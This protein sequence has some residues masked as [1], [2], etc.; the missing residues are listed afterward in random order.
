MS[1]R[2]RIVAGRVLGVAFVVGITASAALA[3]PAPDAELQKVADAFMA[4]WATGDAKAL[5]ALHT[6]EAVRVTGG[7]AAAAVGTAA[8]EQGFTT[9]LGGAYKG[10]QLVVKTNK[11]H[12]VDANTYIGEGTYQITG[13][14]VPAGTPTS[15][16]YLNTMVRQSGVWK[17]ASSAVMPAAK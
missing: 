14:S 15:G 13:G 8:I 10:T 2:V 5:A 4:A 3:Q 9:S 7:T 6:T 12:R 11:Y 17:I 1:K 16:Q